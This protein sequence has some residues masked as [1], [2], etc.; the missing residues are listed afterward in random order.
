MEM[1][2]FGS[3]ICSHRRRTA[4]TILSVTVPE[5]QSRSDWRGDAGSGITP[6]RM[7]SKRGPAIAA[8]ISMAQHARLHW[9][10]QREYLRDVLSSCVSG[11]GSLP[12]STRPMGFP[13][14]DPAQ[15]T[16]EPRVH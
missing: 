16:P 14:L 13:L 2:Y 3:G 10:I 5:T 1:T 8:A 7:M 4:G 6:R 15:D 12:L 11:F 9:Y